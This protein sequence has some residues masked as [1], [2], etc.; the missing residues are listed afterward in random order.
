MVRQFA[1]VCL[2]VASLA[3]AV[4]ADDTPN[5]LTLAAACLERGEETAAVAY[6]TR[7]VTA[8]PDQPVVRATLADLLWRRDQ[9][10]DAQ[11]HYE[12]F[13]CDAQLAALDPAQQVQAYT[14]L[15]AV[16]Q[17]DGD[18]YAEHLHRGIGLYLIARQTAADAEALLCK[19]ARELGLAQ[20]ER[21]QESRPHWYLHLVWSR[22]GQS[23]PARRSLH[24]AADLADDSDL[25]PAEHRDLVLATGSP[26]HGK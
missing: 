14:R 8:H 25:T 11:A 12:R 26:A 18:T 7:H 20:R 13:I 4:M 2:T 21:P 6:L 23:L 3:R 16:A 19:A 17:R 24:Q 10:A 5:D 1:W 15:M 9:W 22:L